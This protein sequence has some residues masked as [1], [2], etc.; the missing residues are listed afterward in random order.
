MDSF[1]A[2]VKKQSLGE[3]R[4]NKYWSSRRGKKVR[5]A[6]KNIVRNFVQYFFRK[7]NRTVIPHRT[8]IIPC[9]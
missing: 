8:V 7:S 9:F 5:Y 3:K 4:L 6:N 2:T 1:A